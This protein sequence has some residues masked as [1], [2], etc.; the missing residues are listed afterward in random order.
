MEKLEV[1]WGSTLLDHGFTTV[2]NLLLDNYAKL[3][4]TSQEAMVI[5]HT[6]QQKAN[7]RGPVSVSEIAEKMGI[8]PRR[9]RSI[10]AGLEKKDLWSQLQGVPGPGA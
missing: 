9:V 8:T 4:L 6:L 7:R 1:T 3:G 5:I 10:L 2:P